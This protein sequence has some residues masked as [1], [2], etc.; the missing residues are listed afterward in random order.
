MDKSIFSYFDYRKF[1]NEYYQTRKENESHF[2]LRFFG[3]MVGIDG[4]YLSKVMSE[5]RHIG[6]GYI[7]PI[8]SYLKFDKNESEYFENLIYFNK[9]K[10]EEQRKL[11]F[12]KLLQLKKA[13]VTCIEKYQYEFYNKWYYTALRNLLEFYEFRVDSSEE[14]YAALGAQLSPPITMAQAKRGIHLLKRLNL[15]EYNESGKYILTDTVISTGES[16]KSLAISNFQ[17]KTIALSGESLKRH[18]KSDRDIS[19]L[20]MN[21][22]E[23]EFMKLKEMI[24]NF[25]SSVI[26]Y[27]S[28][29]PNPDRV[30]QLN[31]QL[32]PLS[33]KSD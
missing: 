3:R 8:L 18:E 23:Q 15:I 25:R 30:F 10:T 9:A 22:T 12:E 32:I 29:A 20:T 13:H 17:E 21:M 26:N 16:W 4:S 1:L 5:K 24:G 27:I 11:Y 31:I 6:D 28:E 33:K 2:S 19:T 7:K 14:E